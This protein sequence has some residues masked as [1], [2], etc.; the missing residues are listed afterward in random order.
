MRESAKTEKMHLL[1]DTYQ[2]WLKS[3]KEKPVV[4]GRGRE[5]TGDSFEAWMTKR[6]EKQAKRT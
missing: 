2:E 5:V 1:V 3:Q 6:V 4:K